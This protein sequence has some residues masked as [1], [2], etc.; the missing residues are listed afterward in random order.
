MGIG[1]TLQ[2]LQGAICLLSLMDGKANLGLANTGLN[3]LNLEV[4]V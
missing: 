2:K 1:T 3:R 4:A